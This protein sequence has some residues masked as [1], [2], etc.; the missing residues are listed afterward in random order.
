MASLLLRK[1]RW[2]DP[3]QKLDRVED[4]LV[5][6]GIIKRRGQDLIPDKDTLVIDGTGLCGAP[7]FVDIHVHL[8]DPGFTYKEDIF[9]GCRAAAAGGF[10]SVCCMPNTQPAVDTPE[11]ITYILKKAENADARVYPMGAVTFGLKGEKLTDLDALA[12]AGAIGFSDDG[13]PIYRGDFMQAALEKAASL[14]RPVASHCEDKQ[15]IK[16]GIINRGEV[17]KKLGVEGMDRTSEDSM[18]ARDIALAAATGTAV[19]ICHVSTKGS[20]AL[21]RDAKRRGIKVTGETA[22]HYLLLTEKALLS[23]DANFRMSPPLRTKEDVEALKEALADGTLEVI[24]TDHA[25]HSPEEKKDFLT[26]PNGVVGLETSFAAANTALVESGWMSL[27]DLVD[28]MSC[29]PCRVMKLPGGSLREGMPADIVLFDPKERWTVQK[30][31]FLSKARNT[32]FEGMELCG[33]VYYTIMGGR[34]TYAFKDK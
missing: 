15:I 26:A 6:D 25:P 11:T 33:K 24:A 19:H 7:G 31:K 30:E 16:K 34:I 17:S 21:I 27:S 13:Q 10:T 23:K 4:L 14:G 3:T 8:R 28:R 1:V 9:S 20:V 32:P 22:P 2:I 29:G 12:Q 5:E 18:T